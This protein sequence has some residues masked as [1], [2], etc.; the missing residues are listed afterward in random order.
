MERKKWENVKK[1]KALPA[2]RQK[3]RE[4]DIKSIVV[5]QSTGSIF[6]II[7][8]FFFVALLLTLVWRMQ[9]DEY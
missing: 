1:G 6:Y 5:F 4:N 9:A 3:Q 7:V 2:A 8:H